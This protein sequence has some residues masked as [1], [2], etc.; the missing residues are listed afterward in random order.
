MT[1]SGWIRKLPILLLLFTMGL[2]VTTG[3][4]PAKKDTERISALECGG[5]KGTCDNGDK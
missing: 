4:S 2:S 1:S 3:N 5:P